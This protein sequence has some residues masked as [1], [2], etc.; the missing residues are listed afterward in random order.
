MA[1]QV[2]Q[3]HDA[4]LARQTVSMQIGRSYLPRFKKAETF[5]E[6][7]AKAIRANPDIAAEITLAATDVLI[8]RVPGDQLGATM[9]QLVRC[10]TRARDASL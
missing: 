1:H 7:S 6:G 9:S 2:L 10:A 4:R 8:A 5:I 3:S